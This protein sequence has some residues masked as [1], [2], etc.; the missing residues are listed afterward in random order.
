[1][2]GVEV[3]VSH[4]G[5][6]PSEIIEIVRAMSTLGFEHE[7]KTD[8]DHDHEDVLTVRW[9][10]MVRHDNEFVEDFPFDRLKSRSSCSTW[11]QVTA[12]Q[13]MRLCTDR[14]ARAE[15]RSRF[16][17]VGGGGELLAGRLKGRRGRA[18]GHVKSLFLLS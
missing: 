2:P 9:M 17:V 16:G 18:Q 8:A 5:I 6:S 1:M 4:L 13:A 7:V 14:N 3:A 12:L 10:E 11:A 15:L